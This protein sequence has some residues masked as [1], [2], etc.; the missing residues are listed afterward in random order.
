MRHATSAGCCSAAHHP[1]AADRSSGPGD[2]AD[3]TAPSRGFTLIEL[4]ITIVVVTIIAGL[5]AVIISQGMSAYTA[6]QSLS[7]ARYQAQLAVERMAR[8]IRMIRSASSADIAS[9]TA[10][11][12]SFTDI[13]GNA[14]QFQR[15]GASAPYTITRNGNTLARNIQTLAFTYYQQDG[16]AAAATADAVWYVVIDVTAVQGAQTFEV[17]TRVHPRNF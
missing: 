2:P 15:T 8:D 13:N 3:R 1:K 6:E 16:V 5:A 14:I 4:I 7:D 17:R 11:N 12:L 9:M 10:T